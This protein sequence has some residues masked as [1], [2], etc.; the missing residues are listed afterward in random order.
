MSRRV[1]DCFP[2]GTELD[3][4]RLRLELLDPVVD[5]FVIVEAPTTFSGQA[6]PLHY[7]E[8]RD[9]LAAYADKV[10][11]VVVDDMP[12]PPASGDRW[13]AERFQRDAIGRGL[14]DADP[15]DLVLVS[16]V[17]ELIDPDVVAGPLQQ[18]DEPVALEMRLAYW[19]GN[20]ELAD[21]WDR[22][23]ACAA[24]HVGYPQ[25]LRASDPRWAVR[26]AGAHLTYLTDVEG[27]RRKL[28]G[29]SHDE[30]DND[31]FR[32]PD[33]LAICLQIAAMPVN[34][35]PLTVRAPDD[36]SA[37]QR[38]AL[39][40]RPDLF[41]FEVPTLGRRRSAIDAYLRFRQRRR[42]PDRV[43]RSLDV[44]VRRALESSSRRPTTQ[45]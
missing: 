38:F 3:V 29:F 39:D 10:V 15:D 35:R 4:L 30:F 20:W 40:R 27:V 23:R 11:H 6:K 21:G 45:P 44:V 8:H 1:F 16:D 41:D 26:D 28:A 33:Y 7:A 25:Q 17:D 24:R 32:D 37:V 5:R 19:R 31:T 2:F 22:A 18:V 9:E 14:V 13:P 36:L 34:G 43:R 12:P 42:L